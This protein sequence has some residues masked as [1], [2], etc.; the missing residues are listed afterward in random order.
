MEE[1]AQPAP[2][3][4]CYLAIAISWQEKRQKQLRRDGMGETTLLIHS[5]MSRA[6]SAEVLRAGG[7][8]GGPN[9]AI[10]PHAN[11]VNPV[12]VVLALSLNLAVND[13][14]AC[15]LAYIRTYII[16]CGIQNMPTIS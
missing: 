14:A 10:F 8:A 9:Y 7:Q 15:L 13:L 1:G 2:P 4:L 3:F 11:H 5:A 6:A 12:C 16:N